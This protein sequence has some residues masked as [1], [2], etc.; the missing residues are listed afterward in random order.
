MTA[1]SSATGTEDQAPPI[2]A[3]A[4]Q[5]PQADGAAPEAGGAPTPAQRLGELMHQGEQ[6]T[7]LLAAI[8]VALNGTAPSEQR[9]AAEQALRS[10]GVDLSAGLDGMSPA[11][12]AAQAAAPILQVAALLAGGGQLWAAQSDEALLAQGHASAQG[13]AAFVRFGLPMLPGL[14]DA[15][16]R[17]GARMLD[18]GTGVAAMAVA[19]AGVLPQVTVVGIDVMPRVLALAARTVAASRVADRVELRE[20]DVRELD[21]RGVYALAWLP[22]P[23]VPE[24]ALREG[25]ARVVRALV[26]GGWVM[27]AHGKYG[28]HTGTMRSTAS[29][30]P[31]SAA[32]PWTITQPRSCSRPPGSRTPSPSPPHP[33]APPSPSDKPRVDHDPPAHP[34]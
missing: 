10:A 5:P 29:K 16:A 25:A 31:R 1:V 4:I 26:P 27:M 9:A 2:G 6:G 13:A 23:F 11:G 20:Q 19:Y 7:W 12:I 24:P 33:A 18:V 15:L 34:R 30:R 28:D 17:P 32:P 21:D 14:S 8:A 3:P 22:A